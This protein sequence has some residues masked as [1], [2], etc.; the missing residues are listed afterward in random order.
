MAKPAQARTR[1]RRA[2]R[3]GPRGRTAGSIRADARLPLAA[4]SSTA[5]RPHAVQTRRL[6][7]WSSPR[8]AHARLHGVGPGASF[9]E[10]HGL[11][12]LSGS[13][14]TEPQTLWVPSRAGAAWLPCAP[15]RVCAEERLSRRP[16]VLPRR[17]RHVHWRQP[18]RQIA[19]EPH[20]QRHWL[21]RNVSPDARLHV[22]DFF[23]DRPVLVEGRR[24]LARPQARPW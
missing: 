23:A 7:C 3:R 19:S 11:L 21:L 12:V 15:R 1:R 22:L 20:Y 16:A 17:E 4:R 14:G 9:L 13:D 2:R 10:G 24:G 5:G 6:H 18:L 8:R